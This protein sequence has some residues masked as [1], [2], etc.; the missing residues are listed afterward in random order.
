MTTL[1]LDIGGATLK[2]ATST[3]E[4]WSRPFALYREPHRLSE[5]LRQFVGHVGA[6]RLAVTMTG[7]LCDCFRT[8]SDGVRAILDAVCSAFPQARDVKVWQTSG[9]FVD[10]ATALTDPWSTAAAN[11][12]AL[13]TF[14]GRFSMGART[15]LVDIGSTTTDIIPILNRSPAP[16]GRTDPDRLATSELIYLGVLRTPLCALLPQVTIDGK[17]YRTM[18]EWF[19]TTQD[20]YLLLG[21]LTED[22][23]DLSTADRRPATIEFA[24]GRL[25]HWIGSDETRFSRDHARSMAQQVSGK[26]EELLTDGLRQVRDES[27]DGGIDQV[28]LSGQGEFVAQRLPFLEHY[29]KHSL[30]D[31]LGPAL[32]KAACAYA[33]AILANEAR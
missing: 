15:L 8:K 9:H 21:D 17:V 28:I 6:D 11:W 23:E 14:A 3:G 32:S 5:E 18:A 19:A 10:V 1:G 29:P 12:H 7:E 4:A 33:V 24:I 20:I 22:S 30:A 2:A 16:R 13:A 25:A 26:I 31:S 27:L